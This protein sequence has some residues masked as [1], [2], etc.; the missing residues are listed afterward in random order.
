RSEA[1]TNELAPD[2]GVVGLLLGQADPQL[3]LGDQA[4][5]DQQLA[6]AKFLTL[7]GQWPTDSS[8]IA[9][10]SGWVRCECVLAPAHAAPCAARPSRGEHSMAAREERIGLMEDL[11]G[12]FRGCGSGFPPARG[13][14]GRGR[15]RG[16]ER[17]R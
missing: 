12:L 10:M 17:P 13:R 15:A 3:V 2:R 9:K 4:L 6:Q 7:L 1:Q 11:P 5:L 16:R 8:A 14:T